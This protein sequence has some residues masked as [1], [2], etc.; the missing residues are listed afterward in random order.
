VLA[1]QL[2][3]ERGTVSVLTSRMVERGWLARLP[4]ENRRTYRLVLTPTGGHLL[5]Q[6]IPRAVAL[7]ELTLSGIPHDQLHQLRTQLALIEAK[8]R[9]NASPEESKGEDEA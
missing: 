4:G 5:E 2:L 8:L 3:I 1:E 9:E 6:A 7:A